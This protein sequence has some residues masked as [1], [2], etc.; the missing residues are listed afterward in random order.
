MNEKKLSFD[1]EI[2]N[3]MFSVILDGG[4]FDF[5]FDNGFRV[6]NHN[7]YEFHFALQGDIVFQTEHGTFELDKGEILIVA[8]YTIHACVK[9]VEK[10]VKTSFCFSFTETKKKSESNI[11][12]LF[13]DYFSTIDSAKKFKA[14]AKYS[15]TIER[16]LCEFYSDSPFSIARLKAQCSLL[17]L[18]IADELKSSESTSAFTDTITHENDV[19]HAVIEEY[20]NRNYNGN[21]SLHSLSKILNLCEKQTSRIVKKEFGITFRDLVAKTRYSAAIYLLRNTEISMS[22]IATRIGY[23]TY[24]GFYNLFLSKSGV[25]PEEYRLNNKK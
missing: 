13:V 23:N 14:S 4:F 18:E 16:I 12:K 9:G 24:N 3:A 5:E 11:Y 25:S 19:I 1:F 22:E 20:V 8:P 10:S 2:E 15:E 21:I 7:T 17:F 6:H